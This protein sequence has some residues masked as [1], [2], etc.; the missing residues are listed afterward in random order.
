MR[1]HFIAVS[2]SNIG[3]SSLMTA[4]KRKTVGAN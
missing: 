4:V 1:K 2:S 3:V